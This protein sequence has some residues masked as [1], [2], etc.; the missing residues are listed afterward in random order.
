M[1]MELLSRV[2]F[3]GPGLGSVLQDSIGEHFSFANENDLVIA[4]E[5]SPASAG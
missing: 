5:S 2:V 3:R 1:G 4:V